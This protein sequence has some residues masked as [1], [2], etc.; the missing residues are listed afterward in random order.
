MTNRTPTIARRTLGR[1]AH[2]LGLATAY[3]T[4]AS[5]G[6]AGYAWPM[7]AAEKAHTKECDDLF[8]T[9]MGRD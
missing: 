4:D 9:W 5:R 7:T 3:W 8:N 2:K 1:I 6:T